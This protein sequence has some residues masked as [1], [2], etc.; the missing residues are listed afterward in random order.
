MVEIHGSNRGI[1]GWRGSLPSREG[2]L[3]FVGRLTERG[4]GGRPPPPR[5]ARPE[6][7]AYR[8]GS[9][10]LDGEPAGDFFRDRFCASAGLLRPRKGC[11]LSSAVTLKLKNIGNLPIWDPVPS[12]EAYKE[13][14]NGSESEIWEEW[15]EAEISNQGG[16]GIAVVDPGESVSFINHVRIPTDVWAVSYIAFFRGS[17]GQVW[18]C[19]ATTSNIIRRTRGEEAG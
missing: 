18:K 9:A 15:I 19:S 8:V 12:V 17:G 11:K 16:D 7:S 13:G 1:T 10:G 5:A 3:F 4:G 2:S 14:A 6:G